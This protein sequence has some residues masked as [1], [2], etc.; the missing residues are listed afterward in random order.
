[1]K[2]AITLRNTILPVIVVL[3]TMFDTSLADEEEKQGFFK[4]KFIDPEDGHFDT[5]KWLLEDRMF[6]PVPIIITEPAVGFGL[7]AALVFFHETNKPTEN[8]QQG[9][10]EYIQGMTHGLPPSMTAVAGAYTENESWFGGVLHMYTY[11]RDTIRY[12]GALFYPSVNLTF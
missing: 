12:N 10:A 3:L 11:K 4:E 5:S 2:M 8:Q 7:G 6:L 1:M 9:E